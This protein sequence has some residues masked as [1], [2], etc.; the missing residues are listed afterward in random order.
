MEETRGVQLLAEG[1]IE[2]RFCV[3]FV[4][5]DHSIEKLLVD[6]I[7][8]A[9]VL[10]CPAPEPFEEDIKSFATDILKQV[11]GEY[12]K[13][14]KKWRA[15]TFVSKGI[16]GVMVKQPHSDLV[17]D[18]F[19]YRMM[20]YRLER[21]L[22]LGTSLTAP[23]VSD[24]FEDLGAL[25]QSLIPQRLARSERKWE[26]E[27]YLGLLK[28]LTWSWRPFNGYMNPGLERFMG[29]P[30]LQRIK[31][32]SSSRFI[33]LIG[34]LGSGKTTLLKNATSMEAQKLESTVVLLSKDDFLSGTD[35]IDYKDWN[36]PKLRVLVRGLCQGNWTDNL[37]IFV[38]DISSWG[39]SLHPLFEE[40]QPSRNINSRII[41]TGTIPDFNE[42]PPSTLLLNV[43][44]DGLWESEPDSTALE[45]LAEEPAFGHPDIR[46]KIKDKLKSLHGEHLTRELYLKHTVRVTDIPTPASIEQSLGKYPMERDLIYHE[47]LCCVENSGSEIS[48]WSSQ[49]LSWVLNACRPL[50]VQELAIAI[51]I[52]QTK[53]DFSKETITKN[54][55]IRMWETC[56]R[57][58]GL[59]LQ[60]ESHTVH[61]VHETAKSS[62]LTFAAD[63]SRKKFSLMDNSD[64]SILCLKYLLI[65]LPTVDEMD[66]GT[67]GDG[68]GSL[69]SYAARYW[70]AHYLLSRRQPATEKAGVGFPD[71][72][73]LIEELLRPQD[74]RGKWYS[75]FAENKKILSA[76]TQLEI[77]AQLGLFYT[78]EK[79]LKKKDSF[80]NSDLQTSLE[81][82]TGNG[83]LEILDLL[84]EKGASVSPALPVATKRNDTKLLGHLLDFT[85]NPE[86]RLDIRD[87]TKALSAAAKNG[88]VKSLELI[89]QYAKEIP[90]FNLLESLPLEDAVKGGHSAIVT[91]IL[92]YFTLPGSIADATPDISDTI[93]KKVRDALYAACKHGDEIR[94]STLLSSNFTVKG[95]DLDLAA[96]TGS[97][98][99]V[100][101]L[102]QK[103]RSQASDDTVD[104][105][106]S[107]HALLVAAEKGHIDIIKLLC[108]AEFP[109]GVRSENGDTVLHKAALQG[110]LE[111]TEYL[112]S[113]AADTNVE[114]NI[115]NN[116]NMTPG[117]LAAKEGHLLIFQALQKHP[118][119]ASYNDIIS[120]AE[121]GHL[122]MV[123][124]LLKLVRGKTDSGNIQLE[125]ALAAAAAKG[126][127]SV[128]RVLRQEDVE[129][130][131]QTGVHSALHMAASNGHIQVVEYLISEGADLNATGQF[132]RTP[133]HESVA[134]PGIMYSLLG[135]GADVDAVDMEDRT[136][137]HFAVASKNNME[138]G[139]LEKS[140]E[141]L[142]KAHANVNAKD[143]SNNTP[144][145]IAA[146][147]S[148]E[149]AASLLLSHSAQS[150]LMNK[151]KATA[152]HIAV[153]HSNLPLVQVLL[154]SSKAS[155]ELSDSKGKIPLH[156]AVEQGDMPIL[157]LILDA[158]KQVV[159]C[160]DNSGNPPLVYAADG[161]DV[162][163]LSA[164]VDAGADLDSTDAIERTALWRAS[165]DSHLKVVKFLVEKG[166]NISVADKFGVTPLNAAASCGE[167]KVV[168]FLLEKGE[169]LLTPDHKGWN[170]LHSASFRGCLEVVQHLVET[171]TDIDISTLNKDGWTPLNGASANGHLEV[172]KFLV[173]S[174]ADIS[175][176]NTQGWSPVNTASANGH[177]EVLKFLIQSGANVLTANNLGSSPLNNASA[178]GHLEIVQFL[179]SNG[180]DVLTVNNQ[181]WTPLNDASSKGH[182]EVVKFLVQ[183]GADIS[184]ANTQGWTPLNTASANGHLEVVKF[185]VQSGAN[186]LTANNLGCSPLNN[187]SAQGH[188]EIVQFL[189]QNGADVLTKNNQ[190]WTPL[191][192]ASSKGHLEVVKFLVQSGADISRVNNFG[193]T[194]LNVASANGHLEVVKFLFQSGADVLTSTKLGWSPL[195]TASAKG[196]LEIVQFLIQN[197]ADV[198]TKNNHG[199]TPLNDA[200]VNGHLEVVKL[201]VQSG[202]DVLTANNTGSTA[203]HR[204]SSNGHDEVVKY[205]LQTNISC[206]DLIDQCGRTSLFFAAARGHVNIVQLLHSAGSPLNTKDRYSATPVFAAV[207]NGQKECAQFLFDRSDEFVFKDGLGRSLAW[208][209]T[210]SGY[211]ELVKIVHRYAKE[212]GIEIMEKEEQVNTSSR[213]P[214]REMGRRW[215][216]V[217]TRVL[218][219]ESDPYHRCKGCVNFI[220]CEDCC[221]IGGKCLDDSHEWAF[222]RPDA[223][224]SN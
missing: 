27:D 139:R 182:L 7:P 23:E 101:L 114:I 142:L 12:K 164:L 68:D 33:Q 113:Q 210:R 31:R 15:F 138:A 107:S 19:E 155:C 67:E 110:N 104:S 96:E 6:L 150:T 132:R 145:H 167:L 141:A 153:K 196:N 123:R 135:K 160:K 74:L 5:I 26:L 13:S 35:S 92:Q 103:A 93:E 76:P 159:N 151:S 125:R 121:N 32:E 214:P 120:A 193:W 102:L 81:L 128:I 51:A 29:H 223:G 152:L 11:H 36:E 8:G 127:L 144:L 87:L 189:I 90:G 97:P 208:W 47:S 137:L 108:Q 211:T 213:S 180:V 16:A 95:E 126:Y 149:R 158:N 49:V 204:A 37:V 198:L 171:V 48:R 163:I 166:A 100:K 53:G 224:S 116:E 65:F 117:Q 154:E 79:I 131:C 22:Q 197:G 41:A 45:L 212:A 69:L 14:E 91:H 21:N 129:V 190:G 191:N 70:P 201:L 148:F 115:P 169:S 216:D 64:L 82:A 56:D 219:F 50:N 178:Q 205:L 52:S 71:Q 24:R 192:D 136:P 109:I 134:H 202:A 194:P 188:L 62:I 118:Q 175:I 73:S 133:L 161:G 4:G 18:G 165:R 55:P 39:Q 9:R 60:K 34:P 43:I 157:R 57:Y 1:E 25:Q 176:P 162:G 66:L 59:F 177:L 119:E 222:N 75:L 124:Y 168:G 80:K 99:L 143:E 156:I 183:S 98:I 58:L 28:S 207:R 72:E 122:L 187:A 17:I 221:E 186:V 44:S 86:C 40:V 2:L 3:C 112:M 146:E 217:C 181:G 179:I 173:E 106:R 78:V 89:I 88:N 218:S 38:D 94:V 170:P 77:A 174:R 42:I 83:H 200:A 105:L 195:N 220:I 130:N 111:L 46:R 206:R 85:S 10:S 30:L 172:V 63:P 199:W 61:L 84:I 209:A 184:R 147:L 140:I 185:L 20:G 203:L 54:I 215:C